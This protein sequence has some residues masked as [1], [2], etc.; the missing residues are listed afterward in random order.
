MTGDLWLP[1]NRRRM[2]RLRRVRGAPG[3]RTRRRNADSG[4]VSLV[5][6][7][8]P[9]GPVTGSCQLG[10]AMASVLRLDW[11]TACSSQKHERAS[12]RRKVCRSWM[13]R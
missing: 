9:W 12:L 8:H 6:C 4:L 2:A 11:Q 13:N 7:I 1:Q 3:N 5:T 10:S